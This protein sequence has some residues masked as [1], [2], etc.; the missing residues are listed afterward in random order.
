MSFTTS[1]LILEADRLADRA[2]RKLRLCRERIAELESHSL[3]AGLLHDRAKQAERE[4]KRIDL[5]RAVL[6]SSNPAHALMPE[7]IVARGLVSSERAGGEGAEVDPT[8]GEPPV[9]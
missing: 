7:Y 1:L 5:Y 2:E 9:T 3:D 8:S 6:K 4:L